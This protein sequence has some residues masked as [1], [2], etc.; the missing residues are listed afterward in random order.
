MLIL[1]PAPDILYSNPKQIIFGIEKEKH[2]PLLLIHQKIW[3]NVF[4][5]TTDY[6][7]FK[8]KYLLSNNNLHSV[9]RKKW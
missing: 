8:S 4:N 5:I 9:A 1:G 3:Y 6:H 2:D 7:A